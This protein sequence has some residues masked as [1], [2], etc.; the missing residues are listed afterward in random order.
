MELSYTHNFWAQFSF[1]IL[2]A[3]KKSLG[4]LIKL[5]SRPEAFRE[6][7]FLLKTFGLSAE[8]SRNHLYYNAA[9]E[10]LDVNELTSLANSAFEMALYAQNILFQ[11]VD[12]LR[13][14]GSQNY[15]EPL[16]NDKA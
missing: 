13:T 3:L 10:V 8:N 14:L 11:H 15:I 16:Q 6:G 5:Q 7:I 4:H 1:S 12:S 9:T 2:E